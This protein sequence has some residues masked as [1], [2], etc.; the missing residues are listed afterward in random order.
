MTMSVEQSAEWE[1]AGETEVLGE[2]PTPVPL[3]PPQIPHDLTCA[4]IWAAAVGSRR[5][6]AW[7]MARPSILLTFYSRLHFHTWKRNIPITDIES[8]GKGV[9]VKV[10]THTCKMWFTDTKNFH[11]INHYFILFCPPPP[12]IECTSIMGHWVDSI[13][14]V[15]DSESVKNLKIVFTIP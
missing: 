5:L 6:T 14:C 11:V 8:D 13:A 3:F 4:R 2:K 15:G 7:A 9:G 10:T 1:S 12:P